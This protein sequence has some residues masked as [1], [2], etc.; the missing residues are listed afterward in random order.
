MTSAYRLY[1][2]MMQP[3]GNRNLPSE[4]RPGMMMLGSDANCMP[5]PHINRTPARVCGWSGVVEET[6][7]WRPS[8]SQTLMPLVLS[9]CVTCE[10]LLP[11]RWCSCM[12]Q[13]HR[14]VMGN[15]SK[16]VLLLAEC[17]A[18][19][20]PMPCDVMFA[21]RTT[22]SPH[23]SSCARMHGALKRLKSW[24]LAESNQLVGIVTCAREHAVRTRSKHSGAS[25]P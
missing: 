16:P 5:G 9:L 2:E 13:M 17:A 1:T 15:W 24:S 14:G 7:P 11:M 10:S 25:G 3:F 6:C 18:S 21:E 23:L 20:C 22:K 19:S 4:H 12:A 8:C